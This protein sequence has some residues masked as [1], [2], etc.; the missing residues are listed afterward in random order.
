MLYR[1]LEFWR[2]LGKIS[3]SQA[4]LRRKYYQSVFGGRASCIITQHSPDA[5][6]GTIELL[7]TVS[8]ISNKNN[9]W[10]LAEGKPK[11]WNPTLPQGIW[12]LRGVYPTQVSLSDPGNQSDIKR[13]NASFIYNRFETI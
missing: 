11:S 13:V 1:I 8:T 2:K 5:T 6:P 3:K 4:G 10:D 7:S 9:P 12:E